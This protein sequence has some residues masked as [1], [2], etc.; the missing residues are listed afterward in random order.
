MYLVLAWDK[1]C[2]RRRGMYRPHD[3]APDNMLKN[4]AFV[5]KAFKKPQVYDFSAFF[6]PTELYPQLRNTTLVSLYVISLE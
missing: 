3:E 2:Y 6:N 4:T 5:P 1:E